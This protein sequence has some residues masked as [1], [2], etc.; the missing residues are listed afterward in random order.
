MTKKSVIGIAGSLR[1]GS[2]TQI[3][4]RLILETIKK[5]GIAPEELSLHSL[6]LP[7]FLGDE[8]EKTI[9]A[10]RFFKEKIAAATGIILA[11]PEYHGSMSG[12]LKNALDFLDDEGLSGKLV[13]V[14]AVMGGNIGGSSLEHIRTVVHKLKGFVIPQDLII[15][16]SREIF[17]SKG[18]VSSDVEKRLKAFAEAFS[19][20][21]IKF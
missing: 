4:L 7:F 18:N 15:H 11:T 19:K 10:V 14:V 21:L 2:Y 13:G 20:A 1:S 6:N 3:I 8:E 17:D 12:T 5:N 16:R 9:D